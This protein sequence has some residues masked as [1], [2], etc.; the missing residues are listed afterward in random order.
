MPDGALHPYVV[1]VAGDSRHAHRVEGASFEDA[2]MTFV[3]TWAP[4]AAGDL[5]VIVEDADSGRKCCYRVDL[6]SGEAEPCS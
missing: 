5:D 3:E 6:G 2:A 4:D 1:H